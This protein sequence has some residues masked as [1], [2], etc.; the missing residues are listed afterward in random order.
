MKNF[1]VKR[2]STRWWAKQI[3]MPESTVRS[4]EKELMQKGY[5]EKRKNES[6]EDILIYT[7]PWDILPDDYPFYIN[8]NK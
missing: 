5:L 3:N 8:L 7:F 6:G 4:C 2:K 1:I